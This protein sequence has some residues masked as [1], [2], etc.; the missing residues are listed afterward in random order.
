MG[1]LRFGSL[2]QGVLGYVTSGDAGVVGRLRVA[3]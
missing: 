3:G 2:G 1:V